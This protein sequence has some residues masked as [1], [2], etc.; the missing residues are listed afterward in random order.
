[1][2]PIRYLSVRIERRRQARLESLIKRRR[3]HPIL[4]MLADRRESV[5]LDAI[6][7]LGLCDDETACLTLTELL[8]NPLASVRKA[9]ALA[10]SNHNRP[11]G[12]FAIERQMSVEKDQ[13][14]LDAMHTAL[15]RMKKS[16]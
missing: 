5:R 15:L 14:V 12:I 13:T 16:V 6:H 10:L 11:N 9:S 1:M 2:N 7:A 4:T 3:I 8:K